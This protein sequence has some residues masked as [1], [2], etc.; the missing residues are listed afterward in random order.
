MVWSAD[1]GALSVV[2][3]RI[4][5]TDHDASVGFLRGK[6]P[7]RTWVHL[8]SVNVTPV[9]A[10]TETVQLKALD[11]DLQLTDRWWTETVQASDTST[12]IVEANRS[13]DK[14]IP[15]AGALLV[16]MTSALTLNDDIFISAWGHVFTE[17]FRI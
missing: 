4:K 7:A 10:T 3:Q 8:R 17:P 6:L 15:L 16:D 1:D 11:S 12:G 5:L 14:V 2:N 9:F 13:A